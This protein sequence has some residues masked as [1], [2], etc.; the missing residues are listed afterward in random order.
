MIGSA[1]KTWGVLVLL[2]LT[3]AYFAETG[4]AG[5]PLALTVAALIFFKGSLVIDHYMEM[6]QARASFRRVLFIFAGIISVMVLLTHGF[7]EAIKN[8]TTI[9]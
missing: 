2:T 8:L 9:Y 6:K 7:S 4:H 3:G 5:W 1:E